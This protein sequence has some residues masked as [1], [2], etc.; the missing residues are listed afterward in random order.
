M[1]KIY[2]IEILRFFTAM[3]IVIYHYQSFFFPYNKLISVN[4]FNNPNI[5]LFYEYLFIFYKYGGYGVHIFLQSLDL[6]LQMF[7][8]QVTGQQLPKNFS[9]IDFQDYILS[10]F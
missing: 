8:Y 7:I 10:I 4:I 3:A 6:Y 1:K 5:Q 2:T 9:L